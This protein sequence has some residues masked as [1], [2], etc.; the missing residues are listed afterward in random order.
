MDD[1]RYVETALELGVITRTQVSEVEQQRRLLAD[2]GLE[3]SVWFLLQDLGMITEEQARRVRK[4]MSSSVVR[5][6]E[7]DGFVLDGRLGSGGM[8]DVFRG[9]N[10]RGELAAVK[11]LASKFAKVEEY[12]RRFEREAR[13]AQRLVHPISAA[14][15]P[16]VK[17][18]APA[19]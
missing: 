1:D 12:R 8:G 3:R 9:R 19:T 7:V 4:G 14:A 18:R 17:P 2:R 13:A 15:C 6:L 16:T 10:A 11:L 5:A